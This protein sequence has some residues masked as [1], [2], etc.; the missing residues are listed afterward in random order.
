[1]LNQYFRHLGQLGF[2]AVLI[3]VNPI[4]GQNNSG[5]IFQQF[6]QKMDSSYQSLE[7][8]TCTF[9]KQER[10]K[11][12]L[13]PQ[14]TIQF[15]FSKP[16]Q[17]YMK[18]IAEPHEGRELIYRRGLNQGKVVA[19]PGSFP[20]ITLNLNPDSRLVM[21]NNRHPVNEAGI[22]NTVRI[23]LEDYQTAQSHP[24]DSVTYFDKGPTQVEGEGSHCFEAQMPATDRYYAASVEICVNL[25]TM[26]PNQLK[27]R[28]STGTLIEHYMYL[29]VDTNPD[30][31][32]LDFDPE[33]PDY[34]F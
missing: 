5:P 30:L 3:I 4:F 13:L 23:I 27:I 14:E 17:I 34:D 33:N 6:V 32:P 22:G 11:G 1:M 18:W 19:H 24:E 26:L 10:I 31:E 28:D 9:K 29:G 16:F 2:I 25:T 12:K 7:G 21:R 15:K 8:Y 20:D